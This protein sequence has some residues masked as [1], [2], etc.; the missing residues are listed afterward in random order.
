MLEKMVYAEWN[1]GTY[2]LIGDIVQYLAGVYDAIAVNINQQPDISPLFWNQIGGSG[3]VNAIVAGAGVS[4]VAVP[5]TNPTVSLN[6][7]SADARLTIT[8]G[9]GTQRILTNNSPITVASGPALT[10]TGTNITGIVI[11]MP[12]VGTA[13]TSAFPTSITTDANGRVS[14][15]V[16]GVQPVVSVASGGSG[17]TITGTPTNPLVNNTSILGLTAANQGT[18]IIIS[19][20]PTN[21]IIAAAGPPA[22]LTSFA[23]F[24]FPNT[25]PAYIIPSIISATYT[26]PA[27]PGSIS[28]LQNN[29]GY[30]PIP[31]NEDLWIT[32]YVRQPFNGGGTPTS[33]WYIFLEQWDGTQFVQADGANVAYY[34]NDPS[35]PIP[36]IVGVGGGNQY[37]TGQGDSVL[38]GL[39]KSVGGQVR[40]NIGLAISGPATSSIQVQTYNANISYSGVPITNLH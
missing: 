36:L 34:T 11:D 30:T 37:N 22:A 7:T 38:Y 9:I 5:P 40:F 27:P 23:G 10:T 39:C 15:V 32:C 3:G 29:T 2:Y 1:P 17:I 26:V 25:S 35:A 16:P 19:G 14:A 28:I 6:L 12:N 24:A 31:T 18:N 13:G 21:P 4:V 33:S 20:T 8:N